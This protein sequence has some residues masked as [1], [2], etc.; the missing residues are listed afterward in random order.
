VRLGGAERRRAFPALSGALR[1]SPGALPQ[2]AA[3]LRLGV[4]VRI[5]EARPGPGILPQNRRLVGGGRGPENEPSLTHSCAPLRGI[6]REDSRQVAEV[7]VRSR[8]RQRTASALRRR[9]DAAL[10]LAHRPRVSSSQRRTTSLFMKSSTSRCCRSALASETAAVA[11]S[12]S[13]RSW[14]AIEIADLALA[15]RPVIK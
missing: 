4:Y 1:D 5:S 14:K 15:P 12:M 9:A 7:E 10:P 3:T 11:T 2:C 6:A 8:L 13:Q